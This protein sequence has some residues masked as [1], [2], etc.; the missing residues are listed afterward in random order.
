M[1][2]THSSITIKPDGV[3]DLS[4]HHFKKVQRLKNVTVEILQ[5]KVCGKVSIGWYRQND[6]VE[7]DQWPAD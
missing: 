5:C 4:P 7:V 1:D 2:G 6:T 3:H